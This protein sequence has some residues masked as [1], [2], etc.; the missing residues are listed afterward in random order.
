MPN[1]LIPE[2]R[3]DK[4]GK[5][6]TRHVRS[7]GTIKTT[8]ALPAPAVKVEQGWSER[9]AFID[10]MANLAANKHIDSA[11]MER[12]LKPYSDSTLK[13]VHDGIGEEDGQV[14]PEEALFAIC[15]LGTESKI[16]EYMMFSP[17]LRDDDD[18]EAIHDYID[19]L[20]A[21]PKLS[22]IDDF[23]LADEDT[24]KACHALLKATVYF[25][26]D[27]GK[28]HPLSGTTKINGRDY[29][30]LGNQRLASLIINNPDRGDSILEFIQKRGFTTVTAVSEMIKDGTHNAVTDGFL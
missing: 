17:G 4:N 20:R 27:E 25:H 19:G 14:F 11:M 2:V 26:E 16:R 22:R 15:Y 18:V 29:P 7:S 9:D 21:Y 12:V 8:K 10:E 3:V 6:V 30:V 28:Y 23:T 5:Q 24:Q 1:N 13:M